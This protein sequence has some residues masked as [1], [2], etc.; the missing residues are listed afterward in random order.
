[1]VNALRSGKLSGAALDVHDPEPLPADHPLWDMGNVFITPH[2]S[3]RTP[4]Y[5]ERAF[6]VFQDNVPYFLRGERLPTQIDI[7]KY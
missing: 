1:L 5:L 2:M 3:A 7:D 6:K 4:Y